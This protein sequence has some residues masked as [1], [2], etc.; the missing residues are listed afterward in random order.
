MRYQAVL[1]DLFGT[2]VSFGSDVPTVRVAAAPRRTT[3]PWLEEAV[4]QLVPGVAFEEFLVA[5]VEVTRA[6]ALA[7]GGEHLEVSSTE[8]FARVLRRLDVREPEIEVV[9]DRLCE[10]HMGYL[11]GLTEMPQE[12]EQLLRE[13]SGRYRIGLVSNFDHGPTARAILA[14][15]GIV[16]LLE[17]IHISDD[18]G[19]RKPHPAIFHEALRG[20]GCAAKDALYVGDTYGDD[21]VGARNAGMDVAWINAKRV[22]L[23]PDH[24]VPTYTIERLT[25]LADVLVE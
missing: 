13:L 9:A 17:V 8:R 14:H 15:H 10:I 7:R 23:G 21:V 1:F 18:F 24:P 2:L 6:I 11:A 16:E 5:A 19:R 20:L 4:A 25:D 22:E 12:H 3:L